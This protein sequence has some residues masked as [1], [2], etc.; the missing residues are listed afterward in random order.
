MKSGRK[1]Y[2][3]T[4]KAMSKPDAPTQVMRSLGNGDLRS[5][6]LHVGKAG[7]RSTEVGQEVLALAMCEV[8]RR[9]MEKGRA[10]L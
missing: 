6:I 10:A 1:I 5:V 2:R 4:V 3:R 9:F 7:L 8:T